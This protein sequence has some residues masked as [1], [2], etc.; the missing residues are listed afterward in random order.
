MSVDSTPLERSLLEKKDREEL[1]SIAA[2]M[3]GKPTSRARKAEIVDLILD[4]AGVGDGGSGNGGGSEP[5]R[6]EPRTKTAKV[7]DSE[8][9]GNENDDAVPKDGGAGEEAETTEAAG[10]RRAGSEAGADDQ[11]QGV[12]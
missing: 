2:A 11:A 9:T 8:D 6:G 5:R 3:G 12:R 4:L 10:R 1:Q 7:S